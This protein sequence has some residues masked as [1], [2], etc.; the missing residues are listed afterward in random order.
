MRRWMM[1]EKVRRLI[2]PGSEERKDSQ[3]MPKRAVMIG[4][5]KLN[6]D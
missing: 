2:G 4:D 5:L 6:G 3:W 1:D